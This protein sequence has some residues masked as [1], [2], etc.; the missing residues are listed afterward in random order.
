MQFLP[1][2]A[3]LKWSGKGMFAMWAGGGTTAEVACNLI[4]HQQL[5]TSSISCQ[6]HVQHRLEGFLTGSS[7]AELSTI[8]PCSQH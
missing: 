7:P 2:D 6:Q 8:T 5:G 3:G 1:S 4:F